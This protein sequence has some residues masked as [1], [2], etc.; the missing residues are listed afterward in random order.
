M[1]SAFDGERYSDQMRVA[2]MACISAG[3]GVRRIG[4]LL[5]LL[6]QAITKRSFDRV[7]GASTAANWA[8]ELRTLSRIQAA[9][10]LTRDE[11]ELQVLASD[12]TTKFGKKL[13]AFRCVCAV[14]CCAVLC[15]AVL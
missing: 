8:G 4:P 1:C 7:P 10:R 11:K 2:V 13:G 14:L 9:E 15:C 12:G 5:Q 6:A 3:V